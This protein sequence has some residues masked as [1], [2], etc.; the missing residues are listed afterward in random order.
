M[1]VWGRL[2]LHSTFLWLPQHGSTGRAA[3]FCRVLKLEGEEEEE[4]EEEEDDDDDDDGRWTDCI[5]RRGDG[6]MH[7]MMPFNISY[8]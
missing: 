4:E 8:L 2:L 1:C 5:A 6:R 7:G 3:L